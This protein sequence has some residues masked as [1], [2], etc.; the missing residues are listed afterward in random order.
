MYNQTGK[1]LVYLN[2]EKTDIIKYKNNSSLPNSTAD[3]IKNRTI[4][5]NRAP[6]Q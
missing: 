2:Y 6:V 3:I 4:K 5:I 1:N